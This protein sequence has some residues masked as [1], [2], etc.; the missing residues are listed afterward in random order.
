[1]SD[2]RRGRKHPHKGHAITADTRAK[3]AKAEKG[4]K[5]PHRGHPMTAETRAKLSEAAKKRAAA[6]G[7]GA[8][9]G[10]ATAHPG[11]RRTVHGT[12]RP[13]RKGLTLAAKYRTHKFRAG[14]HR[15]LMAGVKR[16][17]MSLIHGVRRR[18]HRIVV[19]RVKAHRVWRK[20]K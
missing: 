8:R 14:P 17:R 5:H 19:H 13:A 1:M 7:G 11:T 20:K 10:T 4:K 15:L 16:S 2:A 9:R 12:L 6:R 3:I 18:R